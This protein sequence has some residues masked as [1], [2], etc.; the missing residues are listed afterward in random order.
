MSLEP[1]EIA[2][3]RLIAQL[4][5]PSDA[6]PLAG[7][8]LAPVDVC[9]W[10]LA[11]QGQNY[12]GG[13]EAIAIRQGRRRSRFRTAPAEA[14]LD[15][16]LLVRCWPQRGTLHY[17]AAEDA[18]WLSALG[19]GPVE[20]AARRRRARLGLEPGL[21]VPREAL[22]EAL[23]A[24]E[25]TRRQCYEVFARVGI[26]PGGNRGPHLLRA[27]GGEGLVVQGAR[28]G[29]EEVFRLVGQL[30]V[31][32]RELDGDEALAELATRY[33]GSHGP[34]TLDDLAWWTHLGRVRARRALALGTGY[35]RDGDHY[36]PDWQSGITSAEM[37]RALARTVT[38]P[39]FDEY[40]LGYTDRTGILPD[41]LRPQV[42]TMNGLS[43]HFVV[44]R[45][46]VRGRAE[47]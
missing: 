27:L 18:A 22:H 6:H 30:P 32:Q 3:R 26:D 19:M 34:A 29:G 46:V 41:E 9:R 43:W 33:V 4:L 12:D 31:P 38:L 20:R 10:M 25:L 24:G 7:R 37:N 11:I 42:L 47:R 1:R 15:A 16:G 36:V 17:L 35:H 5:A 23:A 2:A 21:D 40:L 45:G 14:E 13:L 28:R 39:P 8:V 44:R